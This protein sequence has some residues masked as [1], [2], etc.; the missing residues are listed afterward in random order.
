MHS[1]QSELSAASGSSKEDME[2][3]SCV[4]AV[5]AVENM[6]QGN[7]E[8]CYRSTTVDEQ[9]LDRSINMKLD[10]LVLPL[11]AID[12]LV[13]PPSSPDSPWLFMLVEGKSC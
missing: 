12:F 8:H 11:L 10:F 3:P 2:K 6:V 1:S 13:S 9:A 5:Q 4:E 7:A